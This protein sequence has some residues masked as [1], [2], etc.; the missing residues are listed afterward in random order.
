MIA[1][2]VASPSA[3]GQAIT[4][5]A[6]AL[7][8]ATVGSP[9][10]HHVEHERQRCDRDDDRDEHARNPV[11]EPLDRCLRALRF[12][13]QPDDAGEQRRAAHAGRPAT[14]EAV[15]IERACIDLRGRR[16][17]RPAG[18]RRSACSRRRDDAPSTTTPSTG[19]RFAR[20][21]DVALADLHVGERHVD[22]PAVALDVRDRRLQPQQSFERGGGARLARELPAPCRAAP[23]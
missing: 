17:W 3:Q 2:G 10:S 9:T 19:H 18:S 14:Q 8:S 6:T 1:V 23:A 5:T 4:S 22:D 16:S 21:H 7:T 11:G 20:A 12:A 15:L 13:D